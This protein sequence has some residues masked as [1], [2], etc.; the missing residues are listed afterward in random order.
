MGPLANDRRRFKIENTLNSDDY[1]PT[2][3]YA[4]EKD[5][6]IVEKQFLVF[7]LKVVD[8]ILLSWKFSRP[9]QDP[10]PIFIARDAIKHFLEGEDPASEF[11]AFVTD[12]SLIFKEDTKDLSYYPQDLLRFFEVLR[13]SG[14]SLH[15]DSDQLKE[16]LDEK[17]PC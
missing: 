4:E 17:I 3:D 6:V 9:I 1:A 14:G 7:L 2:R 16:F 13:N 10:E 5:L 8:R 12:V 15:L 11:E